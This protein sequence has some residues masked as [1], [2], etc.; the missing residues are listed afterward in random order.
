MVVILVARNL[1][2]RDSTMMSI[3]PAVVMIRWW[4]AKCVWWFIRGPDHSRNKMRVHISKTELHPD[5][6]KLEAAV[7]RTLNLL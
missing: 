4:V 6:T 3:L 5:L 1:V 2:I 7:Y